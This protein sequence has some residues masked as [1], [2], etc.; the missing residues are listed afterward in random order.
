[1]ILISIKGIKNTIFKV[2]YYMYRTTSLTVYILFIFDY[3]YFIRKCS[4]KRFSVYNTLILEHPP[5]QEV[6]DDADT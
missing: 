1:M 5:R 4:G 6:A 3:N 2:T